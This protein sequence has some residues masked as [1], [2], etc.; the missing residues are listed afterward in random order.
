LMHLLGNEDGQ[1]T[2]DANDR[3]FERFHSNEGLRQ[4]FV[5]SGLLL[6]VAKWSEI[7]A[8]RLGSVSRGC[9]S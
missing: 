7:T 2:D 8:L 4:H 5:R 6:F 3:T 9:K 1:A